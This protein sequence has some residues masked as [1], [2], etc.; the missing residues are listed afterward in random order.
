M[1]TATGTILRCSCCER[2]T[3]MKAYPGE[4]LEVKDGR[5]GTIHTLALSPMDVLQAIS[6]TKEGSAILHFVQFIIGSR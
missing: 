4:M 2:E 3:M 5:H 1:T 6:G